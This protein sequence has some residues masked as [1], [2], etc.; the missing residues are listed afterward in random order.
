[1]LIRETFKNK[2]YV[3]KIYRKKMLWPSI[4][5]LYNNFVN[6][7][8]L[9]LKLNDDIRQNVVQTILR[10]NVMKYLLLRMLFIK[11]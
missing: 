4:Y 10:L 5:I 6:N 11:I 8:Y 2:K 3:H 1:M 7:Q 9:N